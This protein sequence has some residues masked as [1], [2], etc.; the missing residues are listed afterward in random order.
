MKKILVFLPVLII[1][2]VVLL[3]I[4]TWF[5]Y[6]CIPCP[7]PQY[8]LNSACRGWQLTRC[9]DM[10][11]PPGPGFVPDTRCIDANGDGYAGLSD[12]KCRQQCCFIA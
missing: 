8:V 6:C 11:Y 4:F 1:A 2:I 5:I 3:A 10:T 12:E 9:E 7:D